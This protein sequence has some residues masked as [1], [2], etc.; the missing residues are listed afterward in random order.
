[1]IERVIIS[2]A[3]CT[4][5]WMVCDRRYIL[6]SDYILSYRWFGIE[7]SKSIAIFFFIILHS[8]KANVRV[9]ELWELHTHFEYV[10]RVWNVAKKN[11]ISK[12]SRRTQT[13]S[14]MDIMFEIISWNLN[15]WDFMH[16]N[17]ST[18]WANKYSTRVENKNQ[19][20]QQQQQHQT[21]F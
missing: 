17:S 5:I 14:R 15:I 11:K 9:Y 13:F 7:N 12:H 3:H 18:V 8:L 2:A 4:Y 21:F 20:Q 10:S 16:S 19:P 6:W 1:M